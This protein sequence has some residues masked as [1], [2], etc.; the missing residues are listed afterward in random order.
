MN[1]KTNVFLQLF[2]VFFLCY[3]SS[4]QENIVVGASP[5]GVSTQ[6]MGVTVVPKLY[7]F[8][9]FKDLGINTNRI[10]SNMEDFEPVDDNGIYG[11]PSI[12]EVKGNID[13]IPWT[14]W[15]NAIS[16]NGMKSY[17]DETKANKIKVILNLKIN[18][19]GWMA[20]IPKTP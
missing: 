12:D 6:Y 8:N 13:I 17:L 4:A 19:N 20:N 2:F 11:K 16:S 18:A 10:F 15:D 3:N 7:D 5:I 14:T 1:A 9:V